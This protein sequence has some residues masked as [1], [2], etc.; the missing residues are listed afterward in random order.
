M[1]SVTRICIVLVFLGSGF[2]AQSQNCLP[3][4][5][6]L[7]T[8]AAVDAF[9]VDFATCTNIQGDLIIIGDET[10]SIHDL[11]GLNQIEFVGGNLTI[12]DNDSLTT[13]H[14]LHFISAV[15]GSVNISRNHNLIDLDGVQGVTTIGENLI[16]GSLFKLE[17][18]E[19]LHNLNSIAG[20]LDVFSCPKIVNFTG[21]G[22][23]NSLDA[24]VVNGC[25]ELI[26]FEGLGSLSTIDGAVKITSNSNLENLSGFDDLISIAGNLTIHSNASLLNLEGLNDLTTVGGSVSIKS[27]PTLVTLNALKNIFSIGGNYYIEANANLSQIVGFLGSIALTTIGERFWIES[28]PALA[29]LDAFNSVTSVGLSLR[30]FNNFSLTSIGGF[31]SL[32]SVTGVTVSSNNNITSISGFPNINTIG[33]VNISGNDKL[34]ILNGFTNLDT[35][36]GIGVS[37]NDVLSSFSFS[38]LKETNGLSISGNPNLTDINLPSLKKINGD[39]DILGNDGLISLSSIGQ[40]ETING[41]LKLQSNNSLN[42]LNGLSSLSLIEGNLSLFNLPELQVIELPVLTEVGQDFVITQCVNSSFAGLETLKKIGNRFY[43]LNN[44]SLVDLQG[45]NNVD[46]ITGNFRI[47]SNDV[48]TSLEGLD[49]AYLDITPGTNFIIRNNPMLSVCSANAVCNFMYDFP[50]SISKISIFNNSPG[51]NNSYEIFEACCDHPDYKTLIDIFFYMGGFDWTSYTG[52]V[53][54]CDPCGMSSGTPWQGITCN[55]DNRVISLDL[56]DNEVSGSIY[57][58][59]NGLTYLESLNLSGN[60]L[61]DTIP[62]AITELDSLKELNLS[63][64]KLEGELPKELGE[65]SKLTTLLLNDNN[66]NG[67]FHQNLT[68]LCSTLTTSSINP[69]NDFYS[70]WDSFCNTGEGSC[71]H[72]DYIALE[73]IHQDMGGNTWINSNNWL[74][75]CDPCGL[76][77]GTTWNGVSCENNRVTKIELPNNNLQNELPV[78]IELLTHIDTLDINNNSISG[79]IPI[80]M[81][82]LHKL[83]LLNLSHNTL[84]GEIPLDLQK[85][86]ALE[87]LEIQNNQFSGT[88]SRGFGIL[89]TLGS[90]EHLNIENNLF[91]GCFDDVLQGLCFGGT[92]LIDCDGTCNNFDN[93]WSQ[94][95]SNGTG[96]C[97]PCGDINWIGSTGFSDGDWNQAINWD[98][99]VVPMNCHEAHISPGYSIKIFPHNQGCLESLEVMSGSL[100]EISQFGLLSVQDSTCQPPEEF[101]LDSPLNIKK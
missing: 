25:S 27:N 58:L 85:L 51:C 22:A 62:I 71:C 97:D 31:N 68:S 6:I 45:L 8:Q 43:L 3:N 86:R 39:F 48:L 37:G 84:S 2:L 66:F 81:Y 65:L 13:L 47:E 77:S 79:E 24:I 29:S 21:L 75:D 57:S 9:S 54:D 74:A 50:T 35:A 18:L 60:E 16:I 96:A 4:G 83:E 40:L 100:L 98:K 64:N 91:S 15:G 69:G 72:L 12:L 26:N 34:G 94:F 38:S 55:Q 32:Q 49:N 23:L 20:F 67:C 87:V 70:E 90:L 46:S 36:S 11:S 5:I 28:N 92:T 73:K 88:L 33:G 56:S 30:I 78:E 61:T 76:Q 95:C 80:T 93:A 59:I 10:N 41:E 7:E 42:S 44:E 17:S 1:R 89:K 53:Q 14:G 19:G 63:N 99:L 52:W 101:I 82:D